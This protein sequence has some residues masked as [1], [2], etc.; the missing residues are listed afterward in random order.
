MG[1]LVASGEEGA[2]MLMIFMPFV[3]LNQRRLICIT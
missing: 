1:G 3:A 2:Q